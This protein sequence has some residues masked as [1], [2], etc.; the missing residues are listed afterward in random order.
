MQDLT[1]SLMLLCAIT[2]SLAFG[3]L[4]AL[5]IC[6]GAFNLLRFHAASVAGEKLEKA[7]LPS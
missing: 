4:A 7:P 1:N 3:V 2:A 5:G 6:Q